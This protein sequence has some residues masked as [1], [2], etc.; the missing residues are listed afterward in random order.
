MYKYLF[1]ALLVIAAPSMASANGGGNSK[2]VGAIQVTNTDSSQ[3]L[4]VAVDPTSSLLSSETLSQFTSRGGRTVNPGGSTTF[5]N[6]KV[7]NHQ[8]VFLLASSSSGSIDPQAD[9]QFRLIRVNKNV[10]TKVQVPTSSM[11]SAN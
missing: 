5:K 3:V 9:P 2:G 10:T 11:N 8:I 4:L 6:L 7:G 1:A